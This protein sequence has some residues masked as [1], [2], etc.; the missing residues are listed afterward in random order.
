M[1]ILVAGA[2]GQL[3]SVFQA[4]NSDAI[5]MN[6]SQLDVTNFDIVNDL[7]TQVNPDVVV[8]LAAWTDVDGAESNSEKARMV[9]VLG[10]ENLALVARRLNS[11]L[12][13][14]SSDYVFSGI[15]NVPWNIYDP[16]L[17][18]SVYGRTKAEGEQKIL[19][20]YGSNSLIFRT[21]WLYSPFRNNFAKIM[22]RMALASDEVVRI[23]DD[24]IGQPTSAI[25][26][27]NQISK[28]IAKN[29]EPG[30]YHATNAGQ[31]TWKGFAEEI[32]RLVGADPNRIIGISTAE[33]NRPAQRPKYSVLSHECWTKSGIAPM[34][35][36]REALA[37]PIEVIRE[38]V[39]REGLV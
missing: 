36:W 27:V 9:N 32:F 26:L 39:I 30:I 21:A 38:S 5:F 17:P 4:L 31:T 13:H 16:Q 34:R 19:Q 37:E 1:K 12:I 10:P 24:Q 2:N 3:G 23:V 7:L 22:I 28:S 8:N 35:D 15:S 25:D 33:L 6:S 20:N 14:V 18:Q 29:L 11:K